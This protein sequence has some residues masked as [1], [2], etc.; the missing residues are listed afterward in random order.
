VACRL[1]PLQRQL[2]IDILARNFAALN[3]RAKGGAKNSLN[4]VLMNLRKACDHPFL[5]E[6]RPTATAKTGICVHKAPA[7][8]CCTPGAF[9]C[10]VVIFEE[11]QSGS[12]RSDAHL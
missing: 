11:Q 12:W 3:N 2:Y 7:L 5:F 4:N 10:T 8:P 1:S 6:V 9:M